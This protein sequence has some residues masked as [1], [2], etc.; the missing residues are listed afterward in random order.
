MAV[1]RLPGGPKER[2]ISRYRGVLTA[3]RAQALISTAFPQF[4]DRR[5]VF[6]AEGWDFQVFEVGAGWLFRFPKREESA[7]R[8]TKEYHLLSDLKQW[9]SLPIPDYQCFCE[10]HGDSGWPFAGY[11]KI[12]GTPGDVAEPI[13]WP[14]VARQLGIFL[15]ELH[16]YPVDRALEAGV[17]RE[18]RSLARWRDEALAGLEGIGSL[19]LD[20]RDLCNHLKSD[21]TGYASGTP[22][23][24]HNDLWAEHIL[25]DPRTLGVSGIIDWGD[26]A[27]GDPAIDLAPVYAW[28]GEQGLRDVLA[29][30][31]ATISSDIVD[32]ARYLATC[33]AIRNLKLGQ[34]LE[35]PQ[36]IEAGR[37]AL[38]WALAT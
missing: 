7:V 27:V 23:L 31:P 1:E 3:E 19:P 12:P 9:V 24:V 38:R 5:A 29:H 13:D 25:I 32:R 21:P 17:P 35:H 36:W 11:I 20:R 18:K 30:Y 15:A 2:A 14:T 10:P 16:A 22:R 37:Q 6:L 4:R 34:D 26:A 8:L 33:L 28:R